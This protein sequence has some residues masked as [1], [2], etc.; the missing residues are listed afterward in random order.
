MLNDNRQYNF[1]AYEHYCFLF[2]LC[3]KFII[4]ETLISPFLINT[5]LM[6]QIFEDIGN[7]FST[8]NLKLCS[9]SQESINNTNRQNHVLHYITT[10]T[11]KTSCM[12]CSSW[13]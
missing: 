13:S 7:S 8:F 5:V 3:K 1:L 4:Q 2:I 12:Q 9:I 10:I 6:T 11:I